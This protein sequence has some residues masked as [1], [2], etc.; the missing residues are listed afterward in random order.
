MLV[1]A[2]L[3]AAYFMRPVAGGWFG[4]FTVFSSCVV[5]PRRSIAGGSV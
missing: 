2:A 1:L 5:M 4:L 3:V